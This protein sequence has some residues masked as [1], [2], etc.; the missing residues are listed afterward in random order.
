MRR[1]N[2]SLKNILTLIVVLLIIAAGVFIYLSPIFEKNSPKITFENNK[3]WN[4]KEKLKL[5]LFDQS[6]IKSY[7]IYYIIDDNK[8]I[9]VDKSINSKQTSLMF[10]IPKFDL[11][12]NIQKIKIAVEA[13]DNSL[14]NFYKVI[15]L[16]KNLN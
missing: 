10:E 7:K 9:L 5:S 8:T 16:M 2:N 3:Y 13:V 6:G 11:D 4:L 15:K 12:I 1:Q 14:W